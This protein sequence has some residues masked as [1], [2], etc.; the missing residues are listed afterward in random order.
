MNKKRTCGAKLDLE[1]LE[2]SFGLKDVVESPD[3]RLEKRSEQIE[4]DLLGLAQSHF[5]LSNFLAWAIEYVE[6][7]EASES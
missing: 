5:Q 1:S 7:W 3:V 2:T 4:N 6:R